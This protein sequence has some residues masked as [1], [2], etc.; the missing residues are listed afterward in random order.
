MATAAATHTVFLSYSR[1]DREAAMPIIAALEDHGISVWWDGLL[2]GG[3]RFSHTTEAALEQAEVVV[4]LWS[5]RSIES[6][7][8]RDEATRGRDRG[9]MISVSLD[10]SEPP[11]GF[12]QIQYIDLSGW[13]GDASAAQFTEL[14]RAV[15]HVAAEPGTQ[16]NFTGPAQGA[17][18][19]LS[20]RKMLLAGGS[21]VLV[22]GAGLALWRGGLLGGSRPD[23]ASIA[24]MA[25]DNLSGDPEQEYFSDGLAEEL[26]ATLALNRQIEVA[27]QTSSNMF[28]DGSKGAEEIARALGVAFI[29][30]GSVRRG[31]D[32][33]RVAARL[34][35]GGT[36]LEQWSQVFER[37]LRDVLAVQGEIATMVADALVAT[38]SADDTIRTERIGGTRDAQALDDFLR[39]VALYD[40]AAS[41]SSDRAALAAFDAA[42]ARD[43]AYAAAHA[44]RSRALT[45]IGSAYS[46]GAQ[47]Q[48]T[49]DAA[50]ASAREAI[51]LAPDLAEGHSALG[52]IL[53]NGKLDMQAARQPYRTSFELGYGNAGILGSFAL[54][55]GFM[56]DFDDAR[57][58]VARAERLDPLN[59]SVFRTEGAVEFAA[60]DYAA[61]TS[62][63]RTALSLNEKVNV[64][65]RLLGDIDWLAG[66]AESARAHYEQEPSNLSRL[67]GLALTDAKLSGAAAGEVRLAQLVTEYGE[68]SL[69]QQAVV[70]A[71]WGRSA[72]ALTAIEQAWQ[73]RDSGL[74]LALNDPLLDPIRQE[75]RFDA[76]LRDLGFLQG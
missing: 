14:L 75:P 31:D 30:E 70:L 1:E 9:C 34:V 46:T 48:A 20:R 40:L 66:D 36:G 44:A 64:A 62:A 19:G 2:A 52:F 10:G 28:R 61:A 41:E 69:Y 60:R 59:S 50:M 67:C 68:N 65:H 25:F 29:L 54:Y 51:R 37:P 33:L 42:I 23:D 53:T 22:A 58:A 39:G 11:L 35:N 32:R 8:V 74:V 71:Q 3:D 72:D 73:L 26:R 43:P 38:L 57:E 7:W 63:L 76:V 47:L 4:V 24:V 12:R 17:S 6:H 5:A 45:V 18:G 49:Y 56:G 16:L 15:G 13:K 21:T 55:A 27:A